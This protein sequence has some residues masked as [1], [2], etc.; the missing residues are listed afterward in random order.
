MTALK[1]LGD[2][3]LNLSLV[4]SP[5]S[6]LTVS[7][8]IALVLAIALSIAAYAVARYLLVR[9]G[10][11]IIES[12]RSQLASILLERRVLHRLCIIAAL[13]VR[14]SLHLEVT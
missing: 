3:L 4:D 10:A 2:L 1:S 12:S 7:R 14:N 11:R 6:G 8:V 9:R 13:G 5:G